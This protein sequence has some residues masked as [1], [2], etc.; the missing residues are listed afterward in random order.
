[1]NQLDH[2]CS[3]IQRVRDEDG[4]EFLVKI[5]EESIEDFNMCFGSVAL[6]TGTPEE[7]AAEVVKRRP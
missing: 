2:L 3:V 6:Y 1:M 5:A 4:D 7:L